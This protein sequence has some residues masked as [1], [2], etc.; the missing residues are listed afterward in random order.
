MISKEKIEV[1]VGIAMNAI[2]VVGITTI[3]YVTA[4]TTKKGA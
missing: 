2:R 1:A 3:I 4:K